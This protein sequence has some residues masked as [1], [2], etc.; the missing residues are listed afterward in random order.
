MK[1]FVKVL[2]LE[3]DSFKYVMTAF[4]GQS[5]EKLK[6]GVLDGPH[7]RQLMKDQHFIETMSEL[8]RI[9]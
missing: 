8:E 2:P 6:A 7:I 1:Q 3:G 9:A 4:S 5:L